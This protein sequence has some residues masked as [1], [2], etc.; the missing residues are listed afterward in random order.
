MYIPCAVSI[1]RMNMCHN[2]RYT[3]VLI[4]YS[5]LFQRNQ[6][7]PVYCNS[8]LTSFW[9]QLYFTIALIWKTTTFQFSFFSGLWRLQKLY[10]FFQKKPELAHP[11]DAF[12]IRDVHTAYRVLR[13]FDMKDNELKTIVL[14]LE[15]ASAY[16]EVMEQVR[17]ANQIDICLSLFF[18]NNFNTI[19]LFINVL[20]IKSG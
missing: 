3:K 12:R 11:V 1:L 20:H 17:L 14:D 19:Q 7:Q 6:N 18:N 13:G 16:R 8:T 9:K 5:F 10:E 4:S 15:S 2:V